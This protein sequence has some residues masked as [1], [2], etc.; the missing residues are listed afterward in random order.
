MFRIVKEPLLHGKSGSFALQNLRFCNVK[1]K[2]PFSQ[3]IIFTK[4]PLQYR[5]VSHLVS[6]IHND[7]SSVSG[8]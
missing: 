2:L 1:S 4:P 7:F 5:G 6:H 3:R 8:T